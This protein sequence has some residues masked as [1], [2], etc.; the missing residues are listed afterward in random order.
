ML[1]FDKNRCCEV[2]PKSEPVRYRDSESL[3][4]T[5]EFTR[6]LNRIGSARDKTKNNNTQMK[7]WGTAHKTTGTGW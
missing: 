7:I 2:A 6:R 5:K 4:S 1:M 3:L